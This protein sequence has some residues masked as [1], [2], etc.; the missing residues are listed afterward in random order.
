MSCK[1]S[2]TSYLC[3]SSISWPSTHITNSQTCKFRPHVF[4][5][6]LFRQLLTRR[7]Q[8]RVEEKIEISKNLKP[9]V[10]VLFPKHLLPI[11]LVPSIAL[12]AIHPG[13]WERPWEWIGEILFRHYLE[14]FSEWHDWLTRYV[15]QVWAHATRCVAAP[16]RYVSYYHEYLYAGCR[17]ASTTHRVDW[18][19]APLQSFGF[20]GLNWLIETW[21]SHVFS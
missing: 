10:V 20:S 19:F 5:V 12:N 2:C 3:S 18:L 16:H 8:R 17:V 1:S 9:L 21:I 7:G 13:A 4:R 15:R 14:G 6:A 11:D